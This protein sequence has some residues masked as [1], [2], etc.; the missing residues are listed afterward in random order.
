[1]SDDALTD[2]NTGSTDRGE[3]WLELVFVSSED[4]RHSVAL[5]VP[6]DVDEPD[7]AWAV[8]FETRGPAC[9]AV[10]RDLPTWQAQGLVPS[11][12]ELVEAWRASGGPDARR[13]GLMDM[14]I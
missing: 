14:A 7:W 8:D 11:D 1:M 9:K 4:E 10:L 13:A 2:C 12:Y 6:V 3:L 5:A